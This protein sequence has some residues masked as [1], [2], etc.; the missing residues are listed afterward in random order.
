ME[1]LPLP[2]W[3]RLYSITLKSLLGIALCVVVQLP[4][5]LN[6]L[7]L[8]VIVMVTFRAILCW[9]NLNAVALEVEDARQCVIE[10]A[11][12]AGRNLTATQL[13]YLIVSELKRRGFYPPARN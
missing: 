2:T 11:K 3:W 1:T 9:L 13:H 12:R 6:R 5:P 4:A 8:I 10:Q 7:L